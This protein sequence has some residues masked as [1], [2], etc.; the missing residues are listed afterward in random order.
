MSLN[1]KWVGSHPNN[2][3]VGRNGRTISFIVLHWIVGTLESADST[4]ANPDRIASA[5]YGVGGEQ[6]HQYV[7]EEDTSYANGNWEKNLTSISIEH[8]GGQ[9]LADGKTRMK[10][11]DKTHETS[12][13]LVTEL[14]KKYGI[15]ADKDHILKHSDVGDKPTQCPGTLDINKIIREVKKN[16]GEQTTSPVRQLITDILLAL[17]G[18]TSENEIDAWE[19]KFTNPKEMIEELL[20]N[21]GTVKKRWIESPMNEAIKNCNENWQSQL[22]T[23]NHKIIEVQQ[24]VSELHDRKVE[25][26]DWRVLLRLTWKRFLNRGG[27]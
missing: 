1:K 7:K 20:M 16:L 8:E 14:C 27:D 21:D 17:K 22:N 23:A 11:S 24:T 2:Y 6:V 10:P 3:M 9:L 19:K 5:T 13:K 25:D 26:F 18:E 4:F 15:P 12:I